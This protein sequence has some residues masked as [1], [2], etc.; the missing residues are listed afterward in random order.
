[1]SPRTVVVSGS[2]GLIGSALVPALEQAGHRVLRLVR[3]EARNQSEIRWNPSARLFDPRLISSVDVVVNLAGESIGKRWTSSRRRR[4]RSSRIDRTDLL[5]S[6]MD[7]AGRRSSVTL[8]NASAV[9]FYG[10]R[11]DDVLDE[12][13]PPGRGFLAEI[14]RQWETA[15][16]VA[17]KRGSRVVTMRTGLV[18]ARHGGALK[19]MLPVFRAGLGGQLGNGRQWMSWIALDDMVRAI[20]WLIDH[21]EISG[22]VNM[23]AP[24]PVTNADFTRAL[25]EAIH[26]PTFMRVPAM[27]LSLALGEMAEETL[28]V[29]QRAVPAVLSASGFIL[30]SPTIREALS[31][32]H[33]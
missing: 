17:A 22:P 7:K 4:I 3:R 8:I 1:M 33:L 29:S 19:M 16:N 12:R 23:S 27:A 21:P 11:G 20:L 15:A 14:C 24:N 5:V 26:R 10:N 28:L 6:A 25:G 31:R 9:G 2:S 13:E 32:L 18:L 30:T